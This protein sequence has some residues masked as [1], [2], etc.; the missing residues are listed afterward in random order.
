VLT[1]RVIRATGPQLGAFPARL[2]RRL[3]TSSGGTERTRSRGNSAKMVETQS[4]ISSP[5]R[6]ALGE[7]LICTVRRGTDR[8]TWYTSQQ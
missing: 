3:S 7:G 4:P 8:K 6:T 2:V 1:T 5:V